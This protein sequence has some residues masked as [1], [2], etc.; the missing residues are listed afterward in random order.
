M[1][2]SFFH[3]QRCCPCFHYGG[4]DL[5]I[6]VPEGIP[7]YTWLFNEGNIRFKGAW[8][9]WLFA[10]RISKLILGYWGVF[11]FLLGLSAPVQKKE[12]WFFRFFGMVSSCI[13]RSLPAGMSST[14]IT[15]FW[16]S[17]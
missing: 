2:G 3:L 6:P 7:V 14:I 17:R 11:L 4:G 15:R 10:E 1:V 13:L 16:L 5:D 12:G 9:Y 8:F